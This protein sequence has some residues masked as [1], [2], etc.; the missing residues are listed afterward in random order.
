MPAQ[1]RKE[2]KEQKLESERQGALR[3]LTYFK[4]MLLAYEQALKRMEE[5]RRICAKN[6]ALWEKRLEKMGGADNES[7]KE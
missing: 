5:N 4:E 7:P 1:S 2:I 3:H 6:V